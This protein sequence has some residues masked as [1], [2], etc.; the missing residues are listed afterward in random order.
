MKLH[1]SCILAEIVKD[2][3]KQIPPPSIDGNA[4]A[5]SRISA[6]IYRRSAGCS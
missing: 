3:S 4:I 1:W 2:A 5:P 6:W